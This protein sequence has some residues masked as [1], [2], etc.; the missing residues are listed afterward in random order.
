ML[1][2]TQSTEAA[3][4]PVEARDYSKFA[5]TEPQHARLPCLLCHK[6]ES[7][8]AG[9]K[10][11]GH[12]PCAGCHE[13]PMAAPSPMCSICHSDTQSGAL[14]PFP[15]LRSFDVAFDHATHARGAAR[16]RAGCAAC[17]RPARK[18]VA[19]SI[20]AGTSAHTTCFACHAPRAESNGR[21]ISSCGVCHRVGQHRRT[22]TTAR[23]FSLNFNHAEHARAGLRCAECH[24]VQAGRAKG[25]Q[26]SSPFPAQ[27]HAPS[28]ARSCMS[29]HDGKRAFGGDDFSS[30]KRCH[31]GN[32]W[33]F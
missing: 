13:Q 10:F 29:C 17:H 12:T 18:G 5:H 4:A 31:E 22:P 23:A 28:G 6:R 15:G 3:A 2:D 14:K 21:D 27:H 26:V 25:R 1:L 7:N 16:S 33:H 11:P 20:P 8:T 9:M 30:C 24:D 19:L 32:T